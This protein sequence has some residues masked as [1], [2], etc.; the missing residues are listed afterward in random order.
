MQATPRVARATAESAPRVRGRDG[1]LTAVGKHLDH[2]LS[3]RGTVVLVEGAAGMGKTRLLAEVAAMA[4]RLSMTVGV[5]AADPADTVVQL[6]PLLEAVFDGPAPIIDRAELADAHT[7]PEQRYWLL[8]DIYTQLE[9]AALASP[10]VICLDDLQWADAGTAA[11]LRTLPTRL[12]T[13]PVGWFLAA[14]PGPRSPEVVNAIDH[15]ERLGGQR[16][17]VGPLGDTAVAEVAADVLRGQPDAALLD[18]VASAGGSPFL[19]IELLGGVRDEHLIRVEGSRAALVSSQLPAR[20]NEMMRGRLERLPARAR[21]MATVAA[22]LGRRFSLDAVAAMAELSPSALLPAL[23]ELTDA[24]IIVDRDGELAFVHDLTFEAVRSSV[25]R[26]VRRAL[27]RQAATV[28]LASGALPVEVALQLADSAETGDEVAIATLLK[29]ADMLG[30]TD[31]GAAADL[32]RRALE[33][34]PQ[35]HPLRGPLVAGTALWLHAAARGD[36]AKSFADTALRQVLP[37]AQE[38]EVRLGIAGMFS[39]SPD[40]RAESCRAALALPGLSPELR[41]RHLAL[42]FHNLVVAG[43]TSEALSVRENAREAVGRSGEPAGNF[44]LDLAES[45]LEYAEG[46]F[47]PALATIVAALRASV[48]AGDE[49]R[50]HLARQWRCEMLAVLDRLDEALDLS[51]E[52]VAA[53]Q[54][55]RQGWALRI[56]ETGRA[57]LLLQ[58]GRVAD[59]AAILREHVSDAAVQQ[60]TNAL[61]AASVTALA[62]V[63]L[64]LGDEASSRLVDEIARETL[65]QGAP[66]VRHQA[67]WILALQAAAAGDGAAAHRWLCAHGE[68]ERLS[69]L[70]L[71]PMD[72]TDETRL[73]HMALDA[74]DRELASVARDAAHRRAVLNPEVPSI[75]AVAAQTR[76]VVD[77]DPVNL[78]KAVDLFELARRPLALAAALEDLGVVAVDDGETDQAVAAFGRAL[79]LFAD[80]GATWDAGR[81]RGRLRAL[82]VRRRLVSPRRPASGW[83]A[84]T[85][86]EAAVVRLVAD[87]LTNREVAAKLFV[88]HHTVSGH[89]R[90]VFTKLGVNSRVELTRLASRHDD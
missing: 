56:F 16:I 78:S 48:G 23:E 89:L 33:L 41:G 19:L 83:T 3:G 67:A 61:D 64:H 74:N 13:V 76:G 72:V 65:R 49:T 58:L 59:A 7:S 28:L 51:G 66:S 20:V 25:P 36:E 29:A 32:G 4:E 60:T 82:G 5:G 37:P 17:V 75:A 43:R 52:N 44:V 81:L 14:R 62:R 46:R 34:A 18:M 84:L 71:F 55:H 73:V 11:A 31:P 30:N 42:L 21:R 15:L 63:A 53:A 50:A 69:V 70:P 39:L 57:R 45:G 35:N 2:L 6:A 85:D 54:R 87:G 10:V 90:S 12:A 26:S 8:E 22:S 47:S 27:D 79:V 77:H 40:T 80:A 88:S 24:N 86:S 38:A 9:R 1:E 68:H